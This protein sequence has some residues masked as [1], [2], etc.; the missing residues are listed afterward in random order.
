MKKLFDVVA[1]FLRVGTTATRAGVSALRAEGGILVPFAKDAIVAFQQSELPAAI[2]AW[3]AFD[4]AA[5]AE[6]PEWAK[7]LDEVVR[8]TGA[9]EEPEEPS[10]AQEGWDEE[11]SESTLHVL[12]TG[13]RVAVMRTPRGRVDALEFPL[14]LQVSAHGRTRKETDVHVGDPS[15]IAEEILEVLE[16]SAPEDFVPALIEFRRSRKAFR[17]AQE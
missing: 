2:A 14:G 11:L 1:M 5:G 15:A 7:E 6:V 16:R 8:G 4:A 17:A 13:E 3:D 10:G 12:R 9:A